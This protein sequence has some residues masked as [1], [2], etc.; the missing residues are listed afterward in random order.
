MSFWDTVSRFAQNASRALPPCHVCGAPGAQVCC[1]CNHV[2][3]H[4]HAYSNF[5]AVRSVCSSCMAEK[6]PWAVEDLQQPS[7][8]EDWPYNEQPWEILGVTPN[9]STEEINKAH[10]EVSR[11]F[12]PDKADGDADRQVAINKARE[13]MLRRAA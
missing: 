8:G 10:R 13:E 11:L 6:F 9:A 4:R 2:G 5:G 3:C 12:H 1:V 7:D